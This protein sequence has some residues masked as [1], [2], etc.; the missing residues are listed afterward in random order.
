MDLVKNLPIIGPAG[1]VLT[2]LYVRA[3]GHWD[4]LEYS[5]WNPAEKDPPPPP[6]DVFKE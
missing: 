2:T 3:S 6:K 1:Q 5:A 4:Y